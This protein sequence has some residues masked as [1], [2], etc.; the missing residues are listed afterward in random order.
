[1]ANA[2]AGRESV[3]PRALRSEGTPASQRRDVTYGKKTVLD[4]VCVDSEDRTFIVE[5]QAA[6][7]DNFFARCVYYASGLYHPELSDGE[8]AGLAAG[9]AKGIAKGITK[10]IAKGRPE[11]AVEGKAEGKAEV[12]KAL[13]GI[14]MPVEQIVSVTGLSSETIEALK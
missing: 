3:R 6:E 2:M 13:L 14:G 10:G 12:A 4:L 8:T 11:G 9:E 7:E 1:M 5:M